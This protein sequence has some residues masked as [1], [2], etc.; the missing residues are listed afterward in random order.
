MTIAT[1]QERRICIWC[2]KPIEAT[3]ESHVL[4]ECFGNSGAQVLPAGTVCKPCNNY[5]GSKIEPSLILDP[6]IHAICVLLRTVDPG[7]GNTFRDRLFDSQHP[8]HGKVNRLLKLNLSLASQAFDLDIEYAVKGQIKFA[9]DRRSVSLIS[10]AIHKL[11]FESCVWHILQGHTPEPIDPL[12]DQFRPVR[13]WAREGQPHPKVRPF[14]RMPTGEITHDWETRLW[15]FDGHFAVEIMLFGD[16][17]VVSLTSDQTEAADHL[18]TWCAQSSRQAW[19]I[20]DKFELL[21][22]GA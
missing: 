7:D 15:N 10:R 11:G 9:Y 12:S 13:A 19:L 3:D 8:P 1:D 5:F 14:A 20:G 6:M 2:N 21:K 16:S 17:F 22:S 18:R 4:P